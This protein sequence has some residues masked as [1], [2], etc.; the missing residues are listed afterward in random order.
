MD[1]LSCPAC[2]ADNDEDARYCD[3]CGQHLVESEAA[4]GGC[5]ACGGTVEDKGEGRG[6][7]AGCGLELVETPA[8]GRAAAPAP[9]EGFAARLTEAILAKVRGGVPVEQ[10]VPDSCREALAAP[11]DGTTA[12]S[13]KTLPCPVCASENP[14]EAPRCA[15]CAVWF[16][17][18]HPAAE[19]PRCGASASGAKCRCGAIL[20]LPAL[21]DLLEPSVKSVCRSCK[22]PNVSASGACPDCG[23]ELVSAEGLRAFA[24]A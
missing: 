13:G 22:Q 7:C 10:A 4:E 1:D 16:E 11:A 24:R 9:D 19:C 2:K 23:A 12:A 17:A 5:P 15:A 20:T 8:E 21:L 6:V 14:E 18:R 3:Q